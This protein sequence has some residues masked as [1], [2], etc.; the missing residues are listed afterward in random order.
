MQLHYLPK[1]EELLNTA[2]K[3]AKKQA[4]QL[5]ERNPKAK[6]KKGQIKKIEV[7][8]DYITNRLDETIKNFPDINSLTE[9][10]QEIMKSIVDIDET[11][12][13]LSKINATSIIIKR[14]KSQKAL[15]VKKTSNEQEQ[16]KQVKEFNGRIGSILDKLKNPIDQYNKIT[17]KLTEMPT[18]NKEAKHLVLAGYP[19]VGKSTI[20]QRLTG[21]KAKIASYAFTT[22]TL[23]LGKYEYNWTTI[24]IIDTPGLLERPKEQRNLVENKTTTAL[25]HLA[26]LIL[27]V[28]SCDENDEMD[29]QKQLFQKIKEEFPNKP[30]IKILNKTDKFTEQKISKIE[31]ELNLEIDI[32]QKQTENE[33]ES[34]KQETEIKELIYNKLKTKK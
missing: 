21:A 16:V 24:E 14:I 20:L 11:K 32:R 2:L 17:K 13:I 23:N 6:T 30:I 31:K 4:R 26:D 19:N 25:K 10:E 5:A 28:Y 1:K 33:L 27:F 9:F 12:K 29:K 15:Q 22:T 3:R 8:A 7:V 34:I 18:L